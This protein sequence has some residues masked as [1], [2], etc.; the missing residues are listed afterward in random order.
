MTHLLIHLTP[1]VRGSTYEIWGHTNVQSIAVESTRIESDLI[2]TNYVRIDL[3]H[4]QIM[5]H[6]EAPGAHEFW[7]GVIQPSTG[8]RGTLCALPF[9]QAKSK[10]A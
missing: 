5:S 10:R 2:L 3:L 4:F 9:E 7:G 6:S 1:V 8:H